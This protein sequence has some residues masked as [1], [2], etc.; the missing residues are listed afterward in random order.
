MTRL[1]CQAEAIARDGTPEPYLP[2]DRP[3][4]RCEGTTAL[5]DHWFWTRG[6]E[7]AGWHMLLDAQPKNAYLMP[8]EEVESRLR[9][10]AESIR[11]LG[12]AGAS[13][14]ER[15]RDVLGMPQPR[16][17]ELR[18]LLFETLRLESEEEKEEYIRLLT[19]H[20]KVLF[21][22]II[23]RG[24]IVGAAGLGWARLLV[25][26]AI[27]GLV[28]RLIRGLEGENGTA[29]SHYSCYWTSFF[30][31]PV[32][33]ALAGWLAVLLVTFLVD[34]K[35]LGN[36]LD[37]RQLPQPFEYLGSMPLDVVKAGAIAFLGGFSERLLPH[38]AVSS[39]GQMTGDR[40]SRQDEG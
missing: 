17:S 25:F 15:S 30:V 11:L 7:L 4:S 21:L 29:P 24:L 27:G 40:E 18:A 36:Q 37:P 28:S 10:S 2:G 22:L 12:K 8:S 23:S 13:I 14:A 6:L 3:G 35:V 1:L 31:S 38:L 20:N 34:I 19:W 32:M 5:Q 33:G 26:G 16:E 39:T 9:S